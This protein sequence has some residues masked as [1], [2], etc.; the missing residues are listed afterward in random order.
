MVVCVSSMTTRILV[1]VWGKPWRSTS[2][3]GIKDLYWEEVEYRVLISDSDSPK[4][5]SSRSSFAALY[6]SIDF[7][8]AFI[9]VLDTVF[10]GFF[11]N[12]GRP[13]IEGVRR[14]IEK[15]YREFLTRFLGI[16]ETEIGQKIEIIVGPGNGKFLSNS[17]TIE[18]S[19]AFSDF[20]S[21]VFAKLA[22]KLTRFL[23]TK[24]DGGDELV[25]YFDTTHGLNFAPALVYD[26]M[27]IIAHLLS[28]IYNKVRIFV[29]NAEPYTPNVKSLE[30]HLV[31]ELTISPYAPP[32]GVHELKLL[33]IFVDKTRRGDRGNILAEKSREIS[34]V[35]D[36]FIK[37]KFYMEKRELS[38]CLNC[39]RGAVVGGY[40]LVLFTFY[41]GATKLRGLIEKC[42]ELFNHNIII[43]TKDKTIRIRRVLTFT[44]EFNRLVES[45][46]VSYILEKAGVERKEEVRYSDIDGIRE[47]LFKCTH[48]LDAK[49]SYDL[50]IIKKKLEEKT[51]DKWTTL[52]SLME[53][54][55]WSDRNFR[56]HSG[57]EANVTCV[58]KEGE[59]IIFR[60][61]K[62]D[63]EKVINAS[64]GTLL[65]V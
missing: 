24:N 23:D 41:V 8:H 10:D 61:N 52:S 53:S 30:I 18:F 29:V 11:E 45:Y 7:D 31:E 63:Y 25:I 56:A 27:K 55:G 39:L 15:L 42:L 22:L 37:E 48:D 35:L 6:S 50:Y 17:K 34:S 44:N 12:D 65:R 59:E 14:R 19:G 28:Y 38:K 13:Q 32:Y 1:S 40:P 20:Y 16:E 49:I 58:K 3:E 43:E 57:L 46:L 47:K 9:I 2:D 21:Y 4:V 33:K 26:S 64:K 51:I 62:D 36:S 5:I 54:G 60:Y